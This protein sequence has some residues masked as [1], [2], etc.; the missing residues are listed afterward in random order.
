MRLT[1]DEMVEALQIY[2]C[3]KF[4]IA[5]IPDVQIIAANDIEENTILSGNDIEIIVYT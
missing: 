2:A 3:D 4:G 5:G 1:Y